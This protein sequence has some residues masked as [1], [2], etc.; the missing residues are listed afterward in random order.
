MDAAQ[1][2]AHRRV[3]AEWLVRGRAAGRAGRL[4]RALG[5]RGNPRGSGSCL[6][7]E[8]A[9]NP[10]SRM[11]KDVLFLVSSDVRHMLRRRETLLWTFVMPVIFFYF[12]G[13]ISGGFGRS[14]DADPI[15]VI[16]PAGGGFLADELITRL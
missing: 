12:I 5:F 15:A 16:K 2:R 4:A 10:E 13:R 8:R 6:A 14:N 9:N 11:L 1:L 7:C 3:D